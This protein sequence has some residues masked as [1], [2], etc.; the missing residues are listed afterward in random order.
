MKTDEYNAYLEFYFVPDI[1]AKREIQIS[2]HINGDF[3][4]RD[5]MLIF[6]EMSVSIRAFPMN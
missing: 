1:L 3:N 4:F 6:T 5:L 2:S